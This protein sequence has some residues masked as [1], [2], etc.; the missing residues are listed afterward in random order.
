M[1]V[2]VTFGGGLGLHPSQTYLLQNNNNSILMGIETFYVMLNNKTNR[3][4]NLLG[5]VL[6]Q[7][8]SLNLIHSFNL[9]N[10]FYYLNVTGFCGFLYENGTLSIYKAFLS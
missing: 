1:E 3:L 10:T 6:H 2:S 7:I 8:K 5:S 9:G 4:I